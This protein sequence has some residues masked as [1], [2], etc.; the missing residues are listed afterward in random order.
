MLTVPIGVSQSRLTSVS[1]IR[2]LARKWP[3][4]VAVLFLVSALSMS[5]IFTNHS[6]VRYFPAKME[7]PSR[8]LASMLTSPFFDISPGRA[9]IRTFGM[10][11]DL[12]ENMSR[13]RELRT[14]LESE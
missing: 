12:A 10:M 14:M 8:Y 7:V 11:F 9:S 1:R 2:S 3:K 4:S 6:E 5:L 13:P